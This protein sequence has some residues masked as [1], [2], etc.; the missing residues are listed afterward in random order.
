MASYTATLQDLA[1]INIWES[2]YQLAD[3]KT[4]TLIAAYSDLLFDFDY[5]FPQADGNTSR[6]LSATKDIFQKEFIRNFYLR[7]IGYET[8]N[9]FKMR[10]QSLLT[11][12]Y[13]KYYL[14]YNDFLATYQIRIHQDL[15]IDLAKTEDITNT[16]SGSQNSTSTSVSTGNTN[17]MFS[18]VPDNRLNIVPTGTNLAPFASTVSQDNSSAN[19]NDSGNMSS[20]TQGQSQASTTSTTNTS[21]LGLNNDNEQYRQFQEVFTGFFETIFRDLEVLFMQ[22]F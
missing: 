17:S 20:Q 2:G 11:I 22:V 9:I 6:W 21:G 19:Q 3:T 7:E 13:D 14:L 8:E 4:D 1:M 18:D 12:N 10:L 16:A 15:Q 5:P